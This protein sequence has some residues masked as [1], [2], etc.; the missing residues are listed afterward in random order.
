MN[1]LGT[2]R[3]GKVAASPAGT[4]TE[5]MP[6]TFVKDIDRRMQAP[7]IDPGELYYNPNTKT[8]KSKTSYS[9]R[10]YDLLSVMNR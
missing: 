2:S 5:N 10:S 9:E 8:L 1:T 6:I 4:A 7:L 3:T